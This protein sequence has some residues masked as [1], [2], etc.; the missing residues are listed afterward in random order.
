MAISETRLTH[1]RFADLPNKSLAGSAF[2]LN[3]NVE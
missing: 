2:G 1:W 3:E